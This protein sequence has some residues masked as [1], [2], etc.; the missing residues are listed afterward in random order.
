MN[1]LSF[2]DFLIELE[3]EGK[4]VEGVWGGREGEERWSKFLSLITLKFQHSF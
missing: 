2:T 1:T 4:G 3:G